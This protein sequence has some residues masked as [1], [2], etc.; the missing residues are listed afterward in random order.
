MDEQQPGSEEKFGQLMKADSVAQGVKV[1]NGNQQRLATD[2]TGLLDGAWNTFVATTIRDPETRVICERE[3]KELDEWV[4]KTLSKPLEK[5][6]RDD[7]LQIKSLKSFFSNVILFIYECEKLSW[8][9]YMI[10]FMFKAFSDI[11][12]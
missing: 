9:I 1:G 5:Q 12:E 2:F 10:I 8:N 6:S 7:E 11:L 4:F 3:V